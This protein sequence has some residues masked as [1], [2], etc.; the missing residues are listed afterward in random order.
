LR[1]ALGAAIGR[2]LPTSLVFDHPTADA[3]SAHLAVELGL[4]TPPAA[5]VVPQ[6]IHVVAPVTPEP[7]AADDLANDDA[8]ALLE[9]KLSHAGY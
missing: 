8:L 7:I 2:V 9:R 4:A 1:N 6:P 3:L 5:T